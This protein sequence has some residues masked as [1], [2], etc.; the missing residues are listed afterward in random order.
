MRFLGFEVKLAKSQPAVEKTVVP[1]EQDG[2]INRLSTTSGFYSA[3]LDVSTNIKDENDIIQRYRDIAT[4]PI[5]DAAIE[6]IVS[7]A[8]TSD[9]DTDSLEIDLDELELSENVKEKIIEEFD[10][11]KNIMNLNSKI[12][13][14]FKRWYID[15]RLYYQILLYQKTTDGIAEIRYIEPTTIRKVRE[16][17]EAYTEQGVAVFDGAEE[18]YIYNKDGISENSTSGITISPDSIAYINSGNIDANTGLALG[19]LHKAIKPVNSLRMLENAM[20]IYR[21]TRAPERRIFYI[22][23]GTLPEAKGNQYIQ[24]IMNKYRNKIVYDSAT[25]EVR[26]NRQHLSM[27]EDFWI[28]RREGNKSTEITTLPGGTGNANIDDVEYFRKSLFQS[29]NVPVS[30][31]ENN[32]VFTMGKTSEITRDELKFTKF[33]DRLRSKFADLFYQ[34]IRIQLIAK[35]IITPEDWDDIEPYIL[36]KFASDNFFSEFKNNEVLSQRLAMLAEL[37]PYIG[38]YFSQEYVFSEILKMTDEEITEMKKQMDK[39]KAAGE[40]MPT[41]YAGNG[42]GAAANNGEPKP[43]NSPAGT[44]PEEPKG[45]DESNGSSSEGD[46]QDILKGT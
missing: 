27:M 37:D 35:G 15:G 41:P 46:I 14:I 1:P 6:D 10:N 45:G 25:G 23:T 19:Y 39:E 12:Q 17:K 2:G 40:G 44:P 4:Y 7:E 28:P 36:I 30:R 42:D 18:Y 22:D 33:I 43:D 26:D 29:L 8:V 16:V 20:I 3:A 5:C 13:D 9:S 38:T 21:I 34:I 24:Q 11:I 32:S 31:L